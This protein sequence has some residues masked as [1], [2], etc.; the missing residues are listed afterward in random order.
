MLQAEAAETS[1]QG[2]EHRPRPVSVIG[3]V[4]DVHS[5]CALHGKC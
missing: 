1:R 4:L 3:Q 2:I 5:R